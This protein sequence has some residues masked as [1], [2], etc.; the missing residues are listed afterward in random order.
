MK[1][2][3]TLEEAKDDLIRV[4]DIIDYCNKGADVCRDL[5]DK[6]F[7]RYAESG[8]EYLLNAIAYFRQEERNN[9]HELPSIIL[10]M[11]NEPL[12]TEEDKE[13]C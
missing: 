9:R 12:Q 7:K 13:E 11:I 8:S 2:H 5:G 3:R 4:G 10:N 6:S 1:I